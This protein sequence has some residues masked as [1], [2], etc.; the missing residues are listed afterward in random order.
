MSKPKTVKLKY[1][2]DLIHV[3]N[4]AQLPIVHH[5]SVDSRH[6]YF[7]PVG[8]LGDIGIIYY[9]ELEKPLSGKFI[10]YNTFTGE[11]RSSSVWT[12]D[13]RYMV[14]PIVEVEKHNLFAEKIFIED[15]KKKDSS[16]NRSKKKNKNEDKGKLAAVL[17]RVKK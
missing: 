1:I 8:M 3:L 13:S 11:I 2:E 5:V 14:V 10:L 6:I 4:V 17:H 16:A 15:G 7:I 9:I 12:S